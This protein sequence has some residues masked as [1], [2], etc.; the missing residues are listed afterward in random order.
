MAVA[1]TAI[2]IYIS[3]DNIFDVGTLQRSYIRKSAFEAVLA[4]DKFNLNL[5]RPIIDKQSEKIWYMV[6]M[7]IKLDK[8]DNYNKQEL[9]LSFIFF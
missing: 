1:N 9:H 6:N 2:P 8:N 7:G 4:S 5:E 3:F